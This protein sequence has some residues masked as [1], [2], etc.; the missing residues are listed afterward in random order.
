MDV[1]Q[2]GIDLIAQGFQIGFESIQRAAEFSI[3]VRETTLAE[4]ITLDPHAVIDSVLVAKAADFDV[5]QFGKFASQIFD[6]NTGAAI[7]VGRVFPGEE[8][9]F[10]RGA[11]YALVM[12]R[13]AVS[14]RRLK[15]PVLYRER[16]GPTNMA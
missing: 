9:G 15:A 2:I 11:F 6:V 13:N 14:P 16:R 7:D 5:H 1:Y 10:H 8:E 3:D 4:W 12:W